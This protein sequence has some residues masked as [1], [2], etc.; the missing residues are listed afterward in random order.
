MASKL[1]PQLTWPSDDEINI[2]QY[3]FKMIDL[4]MPFMLLMKVKFGF[5]TQ[6]NLQYKHEY[7]VEKRNKTV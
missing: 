5:H 1:K 6:V 4:L 2:L 3:I 7:G